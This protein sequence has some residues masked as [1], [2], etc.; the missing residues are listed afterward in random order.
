MTCFVSRCG[1]RSVLHLIGD[2]Y[3]RD[4]STALPAARTSALQQRRTAA[5]LH[6]GSV[7]AGSEGWPGA[8][9]A[10]AAADVKARHRRCGWSGTPTTWSSST[11]HDGRCRLWSSVFRDRSNKVPLGPIDV[12]E[13]TGRFRC[14]LSLLDQAAVRRIVRVE[15]TPCYGRRVRAGIDGAVAGGQHQRVTGSSTRG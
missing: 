9:T 6:D 15:L 12:V 8:P 7:M 11:R 3:L 10:C 1:S 5:V 2:P 13:V 4:R 14:E